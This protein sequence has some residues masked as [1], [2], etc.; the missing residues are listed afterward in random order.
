M[1]ALVRQEQHPDTELWRAIEAAGGLWVPNGY[2]EPEEVLAEARQRGVRALLTR[3][4]DLQ[5]LHGLPEL[6]FLEAHDPVD[7]T[8]AQG[9]ARLRSL[10]V[11]AWGGRLDG[12][13]WPELEWFSAAETPRD[14]G[15]VETLYDHPRVR[16]ISV[17]GMRSADLGELA[18]PRLESLSLSQGPTLRSLAGI[19]RSADVLRRLELARLPNLTSFSGLTSLRRLEVLRLEGLR[20][21]TTLDEV[22]ALPQLQLLDISELRSVESLAPLAGHPTLRFVAFGRTVDRDL[23]PLRDVP[24]LELVHHGHASAWHGDAGGAAQLNEVPAD[25]P[26]KLEWRRLVG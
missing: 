22:A 24:H 20:H 13:A 15:G 3:G 19:E 16:S 26:R 12:S 7:V 2:P 25:D 14:G 5:L 6:R 21:V 1:T 10:G 8:P 4:G 9:L 18:A 23:R 17:A 11:T